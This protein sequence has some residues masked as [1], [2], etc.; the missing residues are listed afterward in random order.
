[1]NPIVEYGVEAPGGDGGAGDGEPLAFSS[2]P[3][4]PSS[5]SHETDGS[6]VGP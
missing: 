3:P 2:V 1:M 5:G 4:Q 6:H